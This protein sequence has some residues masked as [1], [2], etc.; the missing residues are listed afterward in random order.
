MKQAQKM[1]NE[2]TKNISM[3]HKNSVFTIMYYIMYYYYE[4]NYIEENVVLSS[5]LKNCANQCN[6]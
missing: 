2:D 5:H 3:E 1:H 6:T 4:E